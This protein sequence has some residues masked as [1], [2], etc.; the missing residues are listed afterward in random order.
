MADENNEDIWDNDVLEAAEAEEL[1]NRPIGAKRGA[2]FLLPQALV[3]NAIGMAGIEQ[4]RNTKSFCLVAQAPSVDWVAPLHRYFRMGTDWDFHHSKT[5]PPKYQAQ[6]DEVTKD[7]TTQ[8]IAMGGRC[9]G[10]SQQLSLLP[11]AMVAA[12]DM[13]LV[14]PHPTAR[15]VNAVIKSVTGRMPRGLDDRTVSVLDFGEIATSIRSGSSARA[16]VDRLRAAALRKVRPDQ[17][18][19]DAPL[20]E[21][22]HGYGAARQWCNELVQ[23]LDA[24]RRGEIPFSAVSSNV[25]LSGPPGVGKTT[26][27]KS[28]ARS[29]GVP[30]IATSVGSWF[31]NSPGFLDSVIKQIDSAFA[32]ARAAA[33]AILFLDEI[34]AVPNRATLSPRGADWW[35]PVITHLLTVLDGAISGATENL[36]VIG[37][38]NHPEKLDAALVRPGRLNRII[39]I[40]R[41]DETAL[42]GIFRQHLGGELADEDLTQVASLSM[43]ATGANVVEFVKSARRRAR[44]AKRPMMMVDLTAAVA[45]EEERS[46]DLMRRVAIH[47]AGHAVIAHVNGMGRILGVSIVLSG[48]RGGFAHVEND[49]RLPTKED[50]EKLVMQ[51]LGGR[52]AEQV[53]L[54]SVGTG[55]GGS[56][57]SDLAVATRQVALMH[58]GLGM[59]DGLVYRADEGGVDHI[60]ALDPRM[61]AVVDQDLKRLYAET[62]ALAQRHVDL[63]EAV[64]NALI[65]HRHI[66]PAKFLEVVDRVHAAR[67]M[68][69]IGNG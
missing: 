49:G 57:H 37:A 9:L 36:I 53:M 15:V 41:P 43:G 26:L 59:G 28:L 69:E 42:A 8:A 33:P 66:G 39:E 6:Q 17:S 16:C 48:D 22:L 4:I 30:L 65:E 38:T 13:T 20:L 31:A 64:A 45:P 12:A 19:D 21:D 34:D 5:A 40:E 27:M 18:V 1:R 32:Q 50:V 11:N 2:H 47:E 68:K 24:W 14:L 52:A 62:I 58:L 67:Q 23:D 35:L 54:A 10:V 46:P 61:T 29:A 56:E 51:R 60:L 63:I 55:S 7:Q 25:V 3:E 44:A